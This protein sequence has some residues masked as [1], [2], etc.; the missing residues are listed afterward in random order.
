MNTFLMKNST[1]NTKI[2]LFGGDIGGGRSKF[3]E[4]ARKYFN[5]M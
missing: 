2:Q 1:K 5:N 4:N 3:F